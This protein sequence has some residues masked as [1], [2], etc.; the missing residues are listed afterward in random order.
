MKE[1]LKGFCVEKTAPLTFARR[2]NTCIKKSKRGFA[3]LHDQRMKTFKKRDI[4][5]NVCE[6]I[7]KNIYLVE[8]SN[9]NK[10]STEA[11]VWGCSRVNF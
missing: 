5:E 1:K 2:R 3:V 4:V 10:G 6:K 11:A 9:F 8:N 7:A